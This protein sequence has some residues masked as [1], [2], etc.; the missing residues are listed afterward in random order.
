MQ[1]DRI[2]HSEKQSSAQQIESVLKEYKKRVGE[3]VHVSVSNRTTFEFPA[4]LSQEEREIR[5]ANYLKR[6]KPIV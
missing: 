3:V 4:D 1:N 6:H 5:I 2:I